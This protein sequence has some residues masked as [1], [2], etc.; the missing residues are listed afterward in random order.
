MDPRL[1][2]ALAVVPFARVVV[3][4]ALACALALAA[5]GASGPTDA[6]VRTP[7][8]SLAE[9]QSAPD[10][11]S[12]AHAASAGAWRRAPVTPEQ[13]FASAVEA[14][15][16]AE[17]GVGNAPLAVL[18]ARGEGRAILVFDDGAAPIACVAD[19]DGTGVA[20]Q[21]RPVPR[22][23]KATPPPDGALGVHEMF[24][25]DAGGESYSVLVGQY[26]SGGVRD[27]AANFDADA[28]WYTAAT[29][30]GWYAI[31]WPGE[32]KPLAVATSNNRSEVIHS[33]AP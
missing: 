1:R 15:C 14:A 29:R 16:R 8:A 10:P 30:N 5:C 33:Y 7:A 26:G 6:P 21:T 19:D 23:R 11:A 31:W 28:A 25:V 27:V 32:A 9:R 22:P 12:F 20:V 24:V 17:P 13:E 4:F 18:D 2:G 3:L